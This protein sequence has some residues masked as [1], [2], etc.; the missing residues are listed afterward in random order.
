MLK[1]L[2]QLKQTYLEGESRTLNM[3]FKLVFC[4]EL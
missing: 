2:K 3:D 1:G 4:L